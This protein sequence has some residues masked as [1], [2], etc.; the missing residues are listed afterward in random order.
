MSTKPSP[1]DESLVEVKPEP[2]P[3]GVY[4][5]W[6]VGSWDATRSDERTRQ[7]VAHGE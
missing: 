6:D 3:P 4:I 7:E 5:H 2:L 1:T